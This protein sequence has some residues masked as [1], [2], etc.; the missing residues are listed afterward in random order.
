MDELANIPASFKGS[1]MKQLIGDVE[2]KRRAP[3]LARAEDDPQHIDAVELLMRE[4]AQL[5]A[6]VAHLRGEVARTQTG[7][8]CV[9]SAPNKMMPIKEAAFVL[10]M[11]AGGAI[12]CLHPKGIAHKIGGRWFADRAK[13][14]AYLNEGEVNGIHS[15]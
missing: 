12:K 8:Q 9:T 6:E 14:M 5:N 7:S 3:V 13:F 15:S 4:V 11:S 10:Q 1:G 2:P